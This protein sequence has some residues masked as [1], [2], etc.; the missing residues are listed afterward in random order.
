MEEQEQPA[1]GSHKSVSSSGGIPHS[2]SG[3][4]L[5]GFMS[6]EDAAAP[7]VHSWHKTPRSSVSSTYTEGHPAP[8]SRAN[9]AF[10]N[11][12]AKPADAGPVSEQRLAARKHWKEIKNAVNWMAAMRGTRKKRAEFHATYRVDMRD[13]HD[14]PFQNDPSGLDHFKAGFVRFRDETYFT[15]IKFFQD[16]AVTQTPETM[17]IAC[18]DSRVDPTVLMGSGP[19]DI[20]MFRNIANMVPAYERDSNC[21]GTFA[22]LE[23]AVLH[24]KVKHIVVLG[25]RNCGGIKALMTRTGTAGSAIKSSNS[26]IDSWVEIGAPAA[27]RTKMSLGHLPFDVQCQTC[28][29]EAINVSL[30]NLLTF[31]WIKDAVGRKELQVHGW[32]YD[33]ENAT[34]ETWDLQYHVNNFERI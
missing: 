34:M 12:G 4:F 23:Y 26:F 31:P 20:F 17:V 5:A 32:Y 19:G 7:I 13:P 2:S 25:H 15:H 14:T 16:L 28:E 1:N 21:N 6:V 29:R 11:D 9:S 8:I 3:A 18:C 33:L 27:E 10:G 30:A 22:A 24:L